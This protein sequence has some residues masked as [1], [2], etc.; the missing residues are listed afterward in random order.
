[1]TRSELRLPTANCLSRNAADPYNV[2]ASAAAPNDNLVRSNSKRTTVLS[3][4]NYDQLTGLGAAPKK[5]LRLPI[6]MHLVHHKELVEMDALVLCYCV[7]LWNKR[8]LDLV[9]SI[10]H[11]SNDCLVLGSYEAVLSLLCLWGPDCPSY[12]RVSHVV[13]MTCRPKSFQPPPWTLK[14]SK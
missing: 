12:M 6:G 2:C 9:P 1:M 5:L 7:S 13:P 11:T 10:V 3:A 8:G 14:N 4:L